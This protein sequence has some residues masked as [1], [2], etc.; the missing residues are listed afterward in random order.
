[1]WVVPGV[2]LFRFRAKTVV[3]ALFRASHGID[4]Y[5]DDKIGL[6]Y[7]LQIAMGIY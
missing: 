7:E 1:M 6:C 3:G 5:T 4:Y 2:P